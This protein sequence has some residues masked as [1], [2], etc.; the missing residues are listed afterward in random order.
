[1]TRVIEGLRAF[2]FDLASREA[3]PQWNEAGRKRLERR[4]R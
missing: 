2:V 3:G 4:G 1:M